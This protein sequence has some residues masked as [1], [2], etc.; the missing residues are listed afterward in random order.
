MVERLADSV[1]TALPQTALHAEVALAGNGLKTEAII[2]KPK[3]IK[4]STWGSYLRPPTDRQ[5]QTECKNSFMRK[6]RF[7][8]PSSAMQCYRAGCKRSV[9]SAVGYEMAN[10]RPT[11]LDL[12]QHKHFTTH[13]FRYAILNTIYLYI[14]TLYITRST[15][16]FQ[17]TTHATYV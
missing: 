10:R 3:E 2:S 6:A 17:S 1:T 15:P 5:R 7:H 11:E 13:T 9:P 8:S 14:S 12:P 16:P 4:R